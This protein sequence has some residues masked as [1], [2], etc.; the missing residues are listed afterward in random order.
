MPPADVNIS[1]PS[2]KLPLLQISMANNPGLCGAIPNQV[3]FA[4]GFNIHNT[5]LGQPCPGETF[6]PK[7]SY[8]TYE[9]PI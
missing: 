7:L 5:A 2:L 8:A 3:R 9:W 4:H 6:P 1:S